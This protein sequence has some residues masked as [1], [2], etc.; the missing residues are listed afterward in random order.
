MEQVIDFFIEW[1]YVGIFLSAFLAGSVLPFSS[2]LVLV[3]LV[4]A[5]LSP[6]WG[7]V[8]ATA[9]N[10][11]GGMTCYGIGR[12]GKTEWIERYLRISREHIDKATRFLAGKGALMAF[13][14]ALPYIG[15]AIAVVL[16]LMRSNVWVTTLS[17]FLGKLLRYVALL[18]AA[19]GLISLF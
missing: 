6:V 11:L 2:E 13:F 9:G 14:V 17:M 1:G 4:Q 3:A 18:Y 10:T 7:V 16:G 12:L 19:E 8:W 5:G 15:D